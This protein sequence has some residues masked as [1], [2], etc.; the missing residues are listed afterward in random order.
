MLENKKIDTFEQ[1]KRSTIYRK[2]KRKNV[3]K[4]LLGQ[5]DFVLLAFF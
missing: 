3:E 1:R 2:I 5:E 4:D